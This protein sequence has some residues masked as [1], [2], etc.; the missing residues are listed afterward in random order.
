[1]YLSMSCHLLKD[2]RTSNGEAE[3]AYSRKCQTLKDGPIRIPVVCQEDEQKNQ[4]SDAGEFRE[5]GRQE[6]QR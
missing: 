4:S 1:M 3:A 5:T 2:D 6:H